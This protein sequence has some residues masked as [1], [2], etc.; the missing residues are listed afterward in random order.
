FVDD[1]YSF[2]YAINPR[3]VW[4]GLLV[5][6]VAIPVAIA[7][8]LIRSRWGFA[9]PSTLIGLGIAV[10][11]AAVIVQLAIAAAYLS[12]PSYLDHAEAMIAAASWLGLRGSPLYPSFDTGDIYGM[13]YGPTL[14]QLNALFLFLFGPS[15][16]ASK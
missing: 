12:Y 5:L 9:R 4:P 11:V 10:I 16:A 3:L 15:V 2:L 13:I 1:A 7:G 14:F 6:L 8:K